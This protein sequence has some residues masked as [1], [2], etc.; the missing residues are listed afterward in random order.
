M[1]TKYL[2]DRFDIHTGGVDHV[3]VHHTNEV[4][5]SECSLGVHPWVVD[6]GAHRVPRPQG[7]QDLQERGRRAG[8]R[9][10]GRAR[11]STRS[12]SATSSSRPTTASSRT[13]PSRPWPRPAPRCAASSRHAVAA[14]DEVGGAADAGDPVAPS[15]SAPRSGRRWPTTSTRPQALS[16]ASD[17]RPLRRPHRR[18]TAGACWPTSTGPWASAWP[19]PSTRTGRRRVGRPARS[20]PCSPSGRRPGRPRTSPPPT[21]SATSWPPRASR[22]STPPDGPTWRRR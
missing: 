3:R 12:P 17:G 7:P 5:Q 16:V 13:S 20:P 10:P 8:G 18:P 2:G 22:S 11:A 21:A 4:A 6:L 14:R 15:R 19:T 9:H 1:A